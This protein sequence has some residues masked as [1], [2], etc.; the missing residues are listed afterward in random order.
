[1]ITGK[2][3]LATKKD[4]NLKVIKDPKKAEQLKQVT[5]IKTKKPVK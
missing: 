2:E 4:D 3:V 1:M 5:K